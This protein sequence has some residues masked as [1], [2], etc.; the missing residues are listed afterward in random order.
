M[1]DTESTQLINS[2]HAVTH[3]LDGTTPQENSGTWSANWV[4]P[5]VDGDVTFYT[6][7]NVANGNGTT[8]GDE[9]KTN[10]LSYQ[11]NDVGIEE[12]SLVEGIYPNPA[13]NFLNLDLTKSDL[14]VSVYSLNGKMLESI[15][16]E[17]QSTTINLTGY[18]TGI[19]FVKA[20][21]SPMQKFIV[22][23]YS[24]IFC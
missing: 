2:D 8:S 24:A 13:T 11:I 23:K 10:S 14:K 1:A 16:A 6:A 18:K 22:R 15:V 20:G 7:L 4:A 5:E 3:T 12:V 21:N 19:Y 17:G 9:I